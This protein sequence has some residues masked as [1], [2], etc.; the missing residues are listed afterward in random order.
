MKKIKEILIK[1]WTWFK[2]RP[3]IQKLL[4]IF[5]L[6]ILVVFFNP[7]KK[8]NSEII[9]QYG[10]VERGDITQLVSETGEIM[11]SN[12]TTV[13]SSIN[14]IVGDVF[15]DNGDPVRRGSKLFYVNST[16]TQQERAKAYSDY[17]SVKN[18]LESTQIKNI[19]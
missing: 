17:L 9:Y 18:S 3:L 14:G 5:V 15:I 12:K 4:F 19:L 7:F 1:I 16:A 13:V 11:S 8:D 6:F 10:R 2:N